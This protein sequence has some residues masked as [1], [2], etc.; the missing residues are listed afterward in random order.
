MSGLKDKRI[1][2]TGGA[3]GIGNAAVRLFVERGARVACTYHSTRP[4]LPPAVASYRCDI[5]DR[6]AVE[7]V[8]GRMADDLGGLEVLVH[9]AGI[10]GSQAA[11]EVDAAAWDRMFDANAKATVWTNQAAFRRMR[12]S[13]GSIINMGS[14]EGVRGFGGNAVYAAS[15]GA[16]MAWT[17]SVALEWGAAK[18][19]VNCVAPAIAT[20]IFERQMATM[21]PAVL[22]MV[23]AD[24]R[25]SIPLGGTLGDPLYDLAP[26]LAFLAS[27][28]SRF[29]TG[30]TIAVD[31]GLMMLGS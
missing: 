27:D 22:A 12:T 7:T 23:E 15:R 29:I 18:V 17:R 25:R 19:R 28:D 11:E 9:A 16:V 20:S 6:T 3:G 5:T 4:E 14:V 2:V 1:I 8:F 26:V 21:D 31:G 13:G 30:Q 24:L 10:H